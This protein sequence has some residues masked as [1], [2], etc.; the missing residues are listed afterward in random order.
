[1]IDV[2]DSFVCVL[3]IKNGASVPLVSVDM[4][5]TINGL[6][7]ARVQLP[8]GNWEI[9]NIPNDVTLKRGAE[10]SILIAYPGMPGVTRIF[11]GIIFDYAPSTSVKGGEGQ[12]SLEVTLYGR[13]YQLTTGTLHSSQTSVASYLDANSYWTTASLTTGADRRPARVGEIGAKTDFG[14]ALL[15][16]MKE[17]AD[18]AYSPSDSVSNFIKDKFGNDIN[19]EASAVLNDIQPKLFFRDFQLRDRVIEGIVGR[20]NDLQ[21]G[22]WSVDSF[23]KR[24]GALGVLMY[25]SLLETGGHIYMVPFS[26]FFPASI[27]LEIKPETYHSISASQAPDGVALNYQGAV[28]TASTGVAQRDTPVAGF[29]VGPKASGGQVYVSPMPTIYVRTS[30]DV[31]TDAITGPRTSLDISPQLANNLAK[32]KFW[33]QRYRGRSYYV[34]CPYLRLD[35]APLTPVRIQTPRSNE[36]QAALGAS[37]L[38]GIVTSVSIRL[39]ATQGVAET[40]LEVGYARNSADQRDLIET[41]ATHPLWTSNWQGSSVSGTLI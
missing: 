15:L 1:M 27:A 25:F 35:A 34:S 16:S 39:D 17:L 14:Q 24:I 11:S 36:I 41:E 9:N 2:Q 40:T 33:E 31:S 10:A 30:F 18:G 3:S 38:Y 19:A 12:L 20:I 6:N 21:A 28:L 26:P 4:V 37:T 22:D 32:Y 7:K 8:V 29:Y 5:M 13:L 23:S